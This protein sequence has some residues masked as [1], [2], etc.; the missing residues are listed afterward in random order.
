MFRKFKSKSGLL[1]KV[2]ILVED[3]ISTFSLN[4]VS[5]SLS[6]RHFKQK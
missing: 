2:D 3:S 6:L 1:N 4:L 5:V